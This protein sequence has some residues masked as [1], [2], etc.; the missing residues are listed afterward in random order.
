MIQGSGAIQPKKRR[1]L[2]AG[3][4]PPLSVLPLGSAGAETIIQNAAWRKEDF[5]RRF[6]KNPLD[7]SK[8]RPAKRPGKQA[9]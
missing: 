5:R 1:R 4:I 2:A 9:D 7:K 6:P 8:M 3:R